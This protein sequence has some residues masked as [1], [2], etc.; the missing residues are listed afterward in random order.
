MKRL[1]LLLAAIVLLSSCQHVDAEGPITTKY[2]S[3]S[4]ISSCVSVSSGI[5]LI[6]SDDIDPGTII[7][8]TNQNIHSYVNVSNSSSRTSL[9]L[10]SFTIY[11]DDIVVRA[12]GSSK[13]YN[14][15]YASGASSVYIEGLNVAFDN[16]DLDLSGASYF[17]GM[18]FAFDDFRVDISGASTADIYGW[19]TRCFL[20]VSGASRF[21]GINFECDE[22]DVDMSGAS[23][24]YIYVYDYISGDLEGASSLRY[25]GSPY[26]NAYTSGG[27]T[28][29]RY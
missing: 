1:L 23:N 7:I 25:S 19:S 17:N 12:Y 27:S 26:I 24:A 21:Y 18:V 6:L 29:S 28:I 22:L 15:I 8:E 16:F 14:N 5:E 4:T 13:Q 10:N 20:D 3:F 2:H 9:S 11:D